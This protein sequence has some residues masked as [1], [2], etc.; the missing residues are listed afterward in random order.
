MLFNEEIDENGIKDLSMVN[1]LNI[2][3]KIYMLY[4]NQQ[5]EDFDLETSFLVE[6]DKN[7]I[8]LYINSYINLFY[9]YL[10]NYFI[11]CFM[12]FHYIF[13]IFKYF[14]LI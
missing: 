5:I 3:N 2:T 11:D 7:E 8:I 14:V 12:L 1:F 6:L 9:T 13:Y 10:L 4:L